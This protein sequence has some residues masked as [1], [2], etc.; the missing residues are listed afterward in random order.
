M[1]TWTNIIVLF[2][3]LIA[4]TIA[5]NILF[6]MGKLGWPA[7][8]ARLRIFRRGS[9]GEKEHYERLLD[10]ELAVRASLENDLRGVRGQRDEATKRAADWEAKARRLMAERVPSSSASASK[11]KTK[12]VKARRRA[13]RSSGS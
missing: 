9:D 8:A 6:E 11:T 2:L 4:G 1:P 13:R 5:G 12:R 3:V 7:A 10:G